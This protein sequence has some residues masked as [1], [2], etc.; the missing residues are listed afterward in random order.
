MYDNPR[1]IKD[2][3]VNARFNDDEIEAISQVAGLT[4]LQKSTLVR[5]ATLR[6]IE[7]L[8]AELKGEFDRDYTNLK[9]AG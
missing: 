4:G 5:Q 2:H 7:E 3:R 1:H 9:D 6:F 8:R